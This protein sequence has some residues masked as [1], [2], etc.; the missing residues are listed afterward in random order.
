MDN[1]DDENYDDDFDEVRSSATMQISLWRR[2]FTFT[3]PYKAEL[4]VLVVAGSVTALMEMAYPLITKWLID[5]VDANGKQ[6]DLFFWA[7]VY[8]G[9]CL[10]MAVSIGSFI[11][12]TSK[13]RV[14]T[15][16]DIRKA[17]FATLQ[18]LSFSFFDHRPVGWI[19]TC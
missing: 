17:A 19:K 6:A 12:M 1:Y 7:I 16:Y 4:W 11:W 13:I 9:T 3:L 18:N 10:L 15:S 8:L 14:Y 2:L 5:D